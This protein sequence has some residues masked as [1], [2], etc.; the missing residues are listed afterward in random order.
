M[1]ESPYNILKRLG[2]EDCNNTRLFTK[3]NDLNPK[4]GTALRDSIIVG[5]KIVYKVCEDLSNNSS[6][7]EYNI[8]HIVITDGKDTNSKTSET[9]FD[10]FLKAW[11]QKFE[12]TLCQTVL[13]GIALNPN[14]S[15]ELSRLCLF[16]G[17]SFRTFN[18]ENDNI[19]EIFKR[20]SIEFGIISETAIACNDQAI[21][22]INQQTPIMMMKRKKIALLFNLD[23]SSSMRGFRWK[24]LIMNAFNFVDKLSPGDL[25]TSILFNNEVRVL[26]QFYEYQKINDCYNTLMQAMGAIERIG[27]SA[28]SNHKLPA[29]ELERKLNSDKN[30]KSPRSNSSN[31]SS[32]NSNTNN[33]ESKVRSK[34]PIKQLRKNNSPDSIK[35]NTQSKS[36]PNV[37]RPT[38]SSSNAFNSEYNNPSSPSIIESPIKSNP[39][40]SRNNFRKLPKIENDSAPSKDNKKNLPSLKL[41]KL[42]RAPKAV[43]EPEIYSSSSE[44]NYDS[45]SNSISISVSPRKT[46]IRN[47]ARFKERKS[48]N[49]IKTFKSPQPRIVSRSSSEE[50]Y[51]PILRPCK[52]SKYPIIIR[53]KSTGESGC[54]CCLLF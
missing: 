34:S 29:L 14:T 13:V 42:R 30:I 52:A 21:L 16:G 44:S 24:S 26:D 4:G 45:P 35:T 38:T 19:S 43:L 9:E 18:V 7:D 40:S 50:R 27:P 1:A 17:E 22:M 8:I 39:N 15:R 46:S 28:G 12:N 33:L 53:K 32:L 31:K 51:K 47:R 6:S 3:L 11:S 23:F 41:P 48:K 36:K 5:L 49:N 20:I 10:S 54:K 37:P 25:L 2:F